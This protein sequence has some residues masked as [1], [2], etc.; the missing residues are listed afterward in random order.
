[1]SPLIQK[2]SL[3]ELLLTLTKVKDP[4]KKIRLDDFFRRLM[5][6][7]HIKDIILTYRAPE[8]CMSHPC[9]VEKQTTFQNF[10]KS[11]NSE[12]FFTSLENH[13]EFLINLLQEDKNS[14]DML[15]GLMSHE[16]GIKIMRTFIKL[17]KD[18]P[19]SEVLYCN[20]IKEQLAKGLANKDSVVQ[21]RF[22]ELIVTVAALSE[23]NF[24]FM[25]SNGILHNA[26]GLY[27]TKDILLKLNVAEVI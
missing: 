3:S 24:E 21:M 19:D 23:K 6:T 11:S 20:E 12:L 13:P 5:Q 27:D 2:R 25:K 9:Y 17:Y 7:S 1:M 18:H 16:F 14:I 15:F 8:K 4:A 10:V 26:V 22:M